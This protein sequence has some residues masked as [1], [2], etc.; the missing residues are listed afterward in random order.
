MSTPEPTD[1][2]EHTEPAEVCACCVATEAEVDRWEM[3]HAAKD[4][5]FTALLLWL[6]RMATHDLS[7]GWTT[8]SY[9][10]LG[11]LGMAALEAL[12]RLAAPGM[13]LFVRALGPGARRI[14]RVVGTA[15]RRFSR[16]E[17]SK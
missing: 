6:L 5:A 9:I 1:T 4:L 11:A 7:G 3:F 8:W 15:L 13:E 14:G 17:P 10:A 16:K 12:T 2:A